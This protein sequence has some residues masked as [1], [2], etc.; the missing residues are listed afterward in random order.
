MSAGWQ[1]AVA[2]EREK[3]AR[4]DADAEVGGEE[5]GEKRERQAEKGRYYT[6]MYLRMGRGHSE[7]RYVCV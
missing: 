1:L 6:T 2:I 4:P 7:R 3:E 5:E